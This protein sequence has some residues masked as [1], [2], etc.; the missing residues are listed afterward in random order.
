MSFRSR[1]ALRLR[2]VKSLKHIVDVATSTVTATVSV[3]P[4]IEVVASP[5]IAS[6]TQVNEGSTIGSIF[7]RVEV[8]ATNAFSSVPRVYMIV[9]KNPGNNLTVGSPN[10]YGIDDTKRYV[11]HQEMVMVGNGAQTAFPR[12]LFKGVIRIPPRLKRFGYNDK[13]ILAFQ[14]G[15]GESSGIT[16]VCI[17][18]IYK[19]YQ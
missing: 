18:C 7:L 9:F 13:L 10:G 5:S 15:A 12:T 16:N 11:I 1:Q 2:P 14:N 4:V 19:E 8:L 6:P 17:Q 3:I